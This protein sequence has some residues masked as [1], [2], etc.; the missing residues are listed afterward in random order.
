M[1]KVLSKFYTEECRK[2]FTCPYCGKAT[3]VIKRSKI[4]RDGADY[5]VRGCVPCEA[6]V[7]LNKVGNAL[8][9]V[10]NYTL[11]SERAKLLTLVNESY[12]LMSDKIPLLNKQKDMTVWMVKELDLPLHSVLVSQLNLEDCQKM[13]TILKDRILKL[14]PNEQLTIDFVK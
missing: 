9:S 11:R 4:T 1:E 13:K 3:E 14:R 5:L 12:S 10:A 7:G 6:F 2:G 8:G